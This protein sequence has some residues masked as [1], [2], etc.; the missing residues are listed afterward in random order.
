MTMQTFGL[1]QGRINKFKGQILAHAVPFEVLGKTG[2]Q[3]K[4]PRNNSDTY[5]ARRWL[6]WGATST[7]A[8]TINRFFQ[9]GTATS[10]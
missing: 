10:T 2:R 8:N 7:D 9:T 3:V 5:V 6:P 4:L 1:S